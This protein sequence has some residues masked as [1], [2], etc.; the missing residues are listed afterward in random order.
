MQARCAADRSDLEVINGAVYRVNGLA[1]KDLAD[2][3]D[4]LFIAPDRV[5]SGALEFAE[6]TVNA[7]I[8]LQYGS[9]GSKIGV[10]VI[11]SGISNADDLKNASG[12]LRVV[13]QQDFV[14]GGTDDHY[15]HGQPV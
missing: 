8:A 15:G 11:D 4:V 10:A 14:G 3:P 12:A 7:N 1:I 13:Y 6:P 2:D 5:V 9:D